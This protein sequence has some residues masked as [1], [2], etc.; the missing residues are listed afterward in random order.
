MLSILQIWLFAYGVRQEEIISILNA[1]Q[2]PS[3]AGEKQ[4]TSDAVDTW[5]I[6]RRA[7]GNRGTL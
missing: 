1:L 6:N 2:Q 5:G 3:E 4:V 7:L